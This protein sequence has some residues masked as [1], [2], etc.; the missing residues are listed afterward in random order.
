MMSMLQIEAS[1]FGLKMHSGKTKILTNAYDA[2]RSIKVNINGNDVDILPPDESEKY[3]GRKICIEEYHKTELRNR[4]AAAWAAFSQYKSELCNSK[5]SAQSRAK[6]FEAVVSARVLY[7]SASWTF[8]SD[9]EQ[10]LRTTRLRML[11][12]MF[13]GKRRYIDGVADESWVEFV[14]RSTHKAE[15]IMRACGLQEDWV[16]MHRRRKFRFAGR[17]ARVSDERWTQKLLHWKPAHG[18]GRAVGHPVKRWADDIEKYCGGNWAELAGDENLWSAVEDGY[19]LN[20]A[21]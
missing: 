1:K 14:K 3:L 17:T 6:L 12:K 13:G 15:D 16:T 9:M 7:G 18:I 11:R 8:T 21:K 4:I 20:M 10:L 19:V 5:L 2:E